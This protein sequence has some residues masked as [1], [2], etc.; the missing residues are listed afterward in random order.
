[1]MLAFVGGTRSYA[2][3]GVWGKCPYCGGD[4]HAKRGRTNVWYWA[5]V[6]RNCDPWSEPMTAWRLYWQSC[7]PAGMCEVTVGP[8]RADV[9]VPGGVIEFRHNSLSADE[10]REREDFYG[11]MVWVVDAVEPYRSDRLNLRRKFKPRIDPRSEADWR[12]YFVPDGEPVMLDGCLYQPRKWDESV[13]EPRYRSF[14]WKQPKR[15]VLHCR[16]PV[17]LSLGNGRDAAASGYPDVV[18][19]AT[20]GAELRPDMHTRI[21]AARADTADWCMLRDSKNPVPTG[22]YGRDGDAVW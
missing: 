9:R 10:I 11:S 15:S 14:R 6:A 17:L 22:R 13:Y 20:L 16:R 2:T 4:V 19:A 18:L 5:H 3:P 7:F 12:R 1:M 21:L 8:H